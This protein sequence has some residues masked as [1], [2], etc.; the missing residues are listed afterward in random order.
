MRIVP[1]NGRRRVVAETE[2]AVA[3][4]VQ[5]LL[6]EAEDVAE[7]V[8]EVTGSEVEVTA[9][10]N[11]VTFDIGDES[12]TVEADGDEEVV[13]AATSIRRPRRGAKPAKRNVRASSAMKRPARSA[14]KIR[15]K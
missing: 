7:L 6:F 12:Y 3:Q 4:E 8:A 14:Q 5:G 13:E 11:T 9:D 15:R 2:T 10:G 1:K